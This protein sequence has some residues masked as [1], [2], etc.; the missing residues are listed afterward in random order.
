MT[1]KEIVIIRIAEM[2]VGSV[3][4][5][6]AVCILCISGAMPVESMQRIVAL[7]ILPII[8][9][10][11]NFIHLR[12]CYLGIRDKV[13]YY[14][15]NLVATGAFAIV[16]IA[17]Y[18]TA[19]MIISSIM[20]RKAYSWLFLVTYL[21]RF[22]NIGL[23]SLSSI[24]LFHIVLFISIFLAPIGLSWIKLKEKEEEELREMAPGILEV[25]PLEQKRN[26]TEVQTNEIQKTKEK[27]SLS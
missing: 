15:L 1:K 9:I 2:F 11:W 4:M 13:Q 27:D 16:S 24:L 7:T 5:S 12:R 10:L 17:T 3:I 6:V 8:Y 22:S 21:F 18:I 23:S 25:N 19:S 20:L 26:S 14:T